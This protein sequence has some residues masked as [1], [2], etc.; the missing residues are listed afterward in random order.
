MFI[1]AN[2]QFIVSIISLEILF[3]NNNAI[4]RIYYP[5]E[6][7]DTFPKLRYLNISEN[8]IGDWE[9]VDE[10]NKFPSLHEL[11]IKKNPFINDTNSL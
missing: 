1:F 8:K 11:R 9:S 2:H 4:D 5:S 7:G 10:L 6:N 3:V